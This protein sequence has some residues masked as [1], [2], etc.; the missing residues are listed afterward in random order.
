M[1]AAISAVVLFLVTFLQWYSFHGDNRNALPLDCG[2]PSATG[3][4]HGLARV[5]QHLAP[6]GRAPAVALAMAGVTATERKVNFPLAASATALGVLVAILIIYKLFIHRPGGNTYSQSCS[7]IPRPGGDS[8]HHRRRLP[9]GQGGR[10][11]GERQ[12]PEPRPET[13]LAALRVPAIPPEPEAPA[14]AT[15]E[16]QRS[17]LRPTLNGLR[18]RRPE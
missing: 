15:S 7:W 5:H 17:P 9:H 4:G 12:R 11:D 2:R 13:P 6:V 1:I 3:H 8:R 16:C 18:V 10:G 14:A